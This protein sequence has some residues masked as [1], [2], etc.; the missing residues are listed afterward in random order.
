M[1]L[2]RRRPDQT[3]ATIW[4]VMPVGPKKYH[5]DGLVLPW[6]LK[7]H[8]W[9]VWGPIGW[10]GFRRGEHSVTGKRL[11]PWFQVA[12]WLHFKGVWQKKRTLYLYQIRTLWGLISAR[13][14]SFYCWPKEYLWD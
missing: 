8:G 3:C 7:L 2:K 6:W 14:D 9:T 4:G 1:K 5:R 13:P 12:K 11:V 10:G